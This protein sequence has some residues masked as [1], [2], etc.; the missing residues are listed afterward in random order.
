[1]FLVFLHLCLCTWW[2]TSSKLYRV[3]FVGEDFH[4]QMGLRV[5]VEQ[6]VHCSLVYCE[7]NAVV[8]MQILQL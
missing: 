3:A 1:M 7:C 5:L 6:N 4:L 2:C 8:S